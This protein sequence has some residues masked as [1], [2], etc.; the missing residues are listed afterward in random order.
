P[1]VASRNEAAHQSQFT[2]KMKR[3]ELDDLL[4]GKVTAIGE[5]M[6]RGTFQIM[7]PDMIYTRLPS[8]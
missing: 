2:S 7:P 4:S 6:N 8:R 5:F 1:L 3:G